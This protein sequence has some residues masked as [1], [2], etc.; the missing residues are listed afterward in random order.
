MNDF[1]RLAPMM[2]DVV[3]AVDET[4][5]QLRSYNAQLIS[6]FRVVGAV[7][8][9]Y[10]MFHFHQFGWEVRE[11]TVSVYTELGSRIIV[12]G[13]HKLQRHPERGLSVLS[14]G[15]NAYTILDE[16]KRKS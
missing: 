10:E 15:Q 6:L 11:G 5:E 4:K 13:E 12:C 9:Y 1:D 2:R 14:E 8:A 16:A 7:P 3:M